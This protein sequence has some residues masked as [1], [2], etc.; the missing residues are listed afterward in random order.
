MVLEVVVFISTVFNV[1]DKPRKASAKLAWSLYRDGV[2][3]FIVRHP[4]ALNSL[5]DSCL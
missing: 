4:D 2:L 1:L 3:Y 5:T